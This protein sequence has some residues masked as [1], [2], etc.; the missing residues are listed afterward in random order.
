MKFQEGN[1]INKLAQI[2]EHWHPHI[3]ADLNGQQVKL[4]K[5]KGEFVWHEHENEDEM[6][7]ILKGTLHIAFEAE[8]KT[9]GPMDYVVIP[10]GM[11]HKPYCEEEVHVL[12][13]EPRETVNTGK[14]ES[15]LRKESLPRI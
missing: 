8:T 5:L 7:L 3:V 1:I 15:D 10:K 4:A 11:R 2:E 9:Y 14:T 12:L 6:F 13:F